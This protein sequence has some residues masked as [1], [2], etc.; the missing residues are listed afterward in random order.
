[1]KSRTIPREIE[2]EQFLENETLP[3]EDQ[4]ACCSSLNGWYVVTTHGQQTPITFGDWII[5][6]P[7][8]NGFYPCKSSIFHAKYERIPE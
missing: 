2:A 4:K 6:E 5:P 1:M 3:F 8:G 7:D